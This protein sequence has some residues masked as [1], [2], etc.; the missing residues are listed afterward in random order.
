MSDAALLARRLALLRASGGPRT[1]HA[2]PASRPVARPGG[3]EL[4]ARLAAAV[5]GTAVRTAA[6]HVVRVE[7]PAIAIAL[8]RPRLA[9]LPGQPPADVPLVCLDT[10]T[11]G[12]G[13][14]TGTLAFLVGLG[15]WEGDRFRQLQL[16]CPDHGDEP[17]LLAAVEEAIPPEAWLVTYNGRGFDWPLLTTRYRMVGRPA[18]AHAGHLDLLPHVRRLFRHRL[19][20]ARL[21]TVEREMLGLHRGEDV[22]G[23]EIPERYLAFVRGGPVEPIAAIVEHNAEDVRSLGRLLQHLDAQYGDAG[24]RSLA[25]AGDLFALARGFARERR[26]EDA[27]GCL[28]AAD[29]RWRPPA[30]GSPAW[31]YGAPLPAASTVSRE[32]IRSERARTLRRMGR[33]AEAVATWETIAGGGRPDAVRAWIEIAK[34]REHLLRDPAGALEAAAAAGLLL[35][36]LRALD[37][38][39][40]AL[41]VALAARL[42]RLRRRLESLPGPSARNRARGGPLSPAGYARAPPGSPR[43]S[44]RRQGRAPRRARPP[45]SPRSGAPRAG[46]VAG[47]PGPGP[48]GRRGG[49]PGTSRRRR[50]CRPPTPPRR[51]GRSAS[52]ARPAGPRSRDRRGGRG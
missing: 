34:L 2:G 12:L 10:E 20:D 36:W 48:P 21:Q 31:P 30:L 29:A 50:S 5:D 4:A 49:R 26:H 46:G 19:G 37:A 15:W 38:P 41:E 40:P 35:D 7:P 27:L 3:A 52:G 28:D 44:A 23:W 16:L 33:H 42:R 22:A 1:D 32:Q 8:V 39:E 17:A 51:P 24:R 11:T 47:P 13:S 6:G 25:P 18:P 43:G 14:G 9:T 45:R